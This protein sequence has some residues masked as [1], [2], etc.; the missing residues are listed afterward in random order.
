MLAKLAKV[1]IKKK[2]TSKFKAYFYYG[3]ACYKLHMYPDAIAIY[4]VAESVN[5]KDAQL[6]YN[7]GLA[8]FKLEYYS[9]AVDHFNKCIELD[10]KHPHAYNNLAFIYNM[11]QVY[12][13]TMKICKKAKENN[14][15]HNLY[16][17]WAFAEFKEGNLVKAIKKIRKGVQIEPRCADNYI[18]WGLILRTAGKYSSAKFKYEQ[19]LK[20]EPNNKTI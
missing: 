2:H 6:Q 3:V 1:H 12:K 13:E 14:I 19:A 20:L 15:G 4:Q 17:H 9:E 16:R 18:V 7:L 5:D 10:K 11:H 8:F